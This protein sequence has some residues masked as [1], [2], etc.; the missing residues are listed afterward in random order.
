MSQAGERA[1][2]STRRTGG[3]DVVEQGVDAIPMLLRAGHAS[4]LLQRGDQL[5]V[6]FQL[7]QG[8]MLAHL[9]EGGGNGHGV[10]YGRSQR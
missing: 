8:R 10:R 2:E 5:V 3:I 9:V 6:L 1:R 7:L 4:R